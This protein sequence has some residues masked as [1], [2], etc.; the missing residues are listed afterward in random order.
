MTTCDTFVSEPTEEGSLSM[1]MLG[2]R[3]FQTMGPLPNE[4]N[5]STRTVVINPHEEALGPWVYNRGCKCHAVHG[6][7]TQWYIDVYRRFQN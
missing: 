3:H 2:L 7:N 5:E 6:H 4:S 1:L